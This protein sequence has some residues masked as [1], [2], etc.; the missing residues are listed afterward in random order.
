VVWQHTEAT[1]DRH[2]GRAHDIAAEALGA[3]TKAQAAATP[4][5]R[6]AAFPPRPGS[7]CGWCDFVAH[8]PE[9][10]AAVPQR[11]ASWAGLPSD[12]VSTVD[13]LLD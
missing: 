1:L 4:D 7:M 2:L 12:I 8:C 11:T 6:D 3:Q 5:E 9:G 13:D 10:R